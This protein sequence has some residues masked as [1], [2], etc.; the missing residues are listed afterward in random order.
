MW[1]TEFGDFRYER[2][3]LILGRDLFSFIVAPRLHSAVA[4][5]V[6]RSFPE[7]Q[8]MRWLLLTMRKQICIANFIYFHQH[9]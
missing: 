3:S 9:N 4:Q 1:D 6:S 7:G 5:T 8:P 2:V